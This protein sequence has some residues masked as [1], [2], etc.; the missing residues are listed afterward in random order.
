MSQFVFA[1]HSEIPSVPIPQGAHDILTSVDDVAA[2]ITYETPQGAADLV[3]FFDDPGRGWDGEFMTINGVAEFAN[4]DGTFGSDGAYYQEE[5]GESDTPVNE[6]DL[7]FPDFSSAVTAA[8][9]FVPVAL[10][11][12]VLSVGDDLLTA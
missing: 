4:P 5:R 2:T 11:L 1:G 9:P 12:G 7:L 6:T 3:F 8:P 10:D